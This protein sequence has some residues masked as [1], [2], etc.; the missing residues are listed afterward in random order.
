MKKKATPKPYNWD[1]KIM[2]AIRRIWK[3]SPERRAAIDAAR[4]DDG[5]KLV[6]C[7]VCRACVHEKLAAVDHVDPCVPLSGF[8]SWDDYIRRMRE[9]KMQILCEACHKAKTKTENAARAMH[10]REAKR[11]IKCKT[12]K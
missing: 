8:V 1:Q 3:F 12:K 4:C 7:A 6:Q 9:N 11:A 2:S 10:K 5:T